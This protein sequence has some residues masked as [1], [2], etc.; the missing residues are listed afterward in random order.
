[1][2]E[3]ARSGEPGSWLFYKVLGGLD[4]SVCPRRCAYL[5]V[6]VARSGGLEPGCFTRYQGMRWECLPVKEFLSLAE[7]PRP[8]KLA[9]KVKQVKMGHFLC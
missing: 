7:C 1:V 8:G 2:G 4:V 3:V 9:P 6:E 5:R